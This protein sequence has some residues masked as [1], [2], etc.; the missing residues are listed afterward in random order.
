MRRNNEAAGR[1][2]ARE[3][4]RISAELKGYLRAHKGP[5]KSA[6]L[7]YSHEEGPADCT[8]GRGIIAKMMNGQVCYVWQCRTAPLLVCSR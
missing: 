1:Q 2:E 5:Y 4:A 6:H 7:I 3:S 8:D